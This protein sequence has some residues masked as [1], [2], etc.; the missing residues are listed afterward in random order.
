MKPDAVLVNIGRG[1]LV[2]EALFCENLRRYLARE[3]LLNVVDP[4]RGY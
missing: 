3:L 2:D 4:A 1:A